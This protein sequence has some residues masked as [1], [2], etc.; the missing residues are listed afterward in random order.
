V[1]AVKAAAAASRLKRLVNLMVS[2]RFV[3]IGLAELTIDD[4]LQRQRCMQ[5]QE[6][7]DG[8]GRAFTEE[9]RS[10]VRLFLSLVVA[11]GSSDIA[12]DVPQALK[13]LF[14]PIRAGNKPP[15]ARSRS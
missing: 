15:L 9:S 8:V 7:G 1:L 4:Q 6:K 5:R 11:S 12:R 3:V 14:Q 2:L 10:A 13:A